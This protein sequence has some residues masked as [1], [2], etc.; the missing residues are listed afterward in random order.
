MEKKTKMENEKKGLQ[1]FCCG[2][3]IT[4]VEEGVNESDFYV[5]QECGKTYN[6]IMG[7]ESQDAQELNR[8]FGVTE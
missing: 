6:V 2:V 8:A 4:E 5:C 7:Q 3:E 1:V